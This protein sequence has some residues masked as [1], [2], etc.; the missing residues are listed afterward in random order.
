MLASLKSAAGW[1]VRWASLVVQLVKNPVKLVK[2]GEL[3]KGR[4][5]H[6]I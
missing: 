3:G 5:S 1:R 6:L 4:C 2:A